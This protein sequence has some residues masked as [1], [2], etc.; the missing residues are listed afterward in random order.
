MYL[1][2]RGK[3]LSQREETLPVP[4]QWRHNGRDCVSPAYRFFTQL[5]VQAQIKESI[6]APRHWPLWG[7]FIG[8]FLAQTASNAEMLPFDDVIMKR[9]PSIGDPLSCSVHN[10]WDELPLLILLRNKIFSRLS[11]SLYSSTFRRYLQ[12]DLISQA[13]L[14]R[15]S[16]GMVLRNGMRNYVN[17]GMEALHI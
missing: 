14:M 4:L 11:L 13:V 1:W 6:E 12:K 15:Y 9:I 10:C 2:S 17:F 5:F 8:D 7:E 3:R 16:L